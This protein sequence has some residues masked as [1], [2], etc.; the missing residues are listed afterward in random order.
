MMVGCRARTYPTSAAQPASSFVVCQRAAGV[1]DQA[2]SK[3]AL[4]TSMPTL[5]GSAIALL[6]LDHSTVRA[7]PCDASSRSIYCRSSDRRCADAAL[8]LQDGLDPRESR[9]AASVIEG[10][11]I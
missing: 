2:T 5:Q 4:E 8:R 10:I 9:A 11:K 7:Q 1:V 3:V 6:S